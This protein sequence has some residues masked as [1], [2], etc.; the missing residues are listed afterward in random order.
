MEMTCSQTPKG[1]RQVLRN[2]GS[3]K[4]L[5]LRQQMLLGIGP[6]P[7]ALLFDRVSTLR[8]EIMPLRNWVRFLGALQL[9]E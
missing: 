1:E 9:F 3:L 5:Y 8:S 7:V 4:S 2:G 6:F